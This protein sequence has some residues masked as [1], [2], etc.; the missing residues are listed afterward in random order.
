MPKPLYS[1]PIRFVQI[2]V[3]LVLCGI[4]GIAQTSPP[5]DTFDPTKARST[6]TEISALDD[7]TQSYWVYVPSRYTPTRTWPILYAFDPFGR[8]KVAVELYKNAAERYG[9]IVAGSNNSRNGRGGNSMTA[10]QAMWEDTHRRFAVNQDRAYTTGMSGGARVATAFALYCSNCNI[11]GVIA[12]AAGYPQLKGTA[13]QP[14]NTRFLYYVTVGAEDFNYPELMALRKK[15]E[16]AAEPCKVKIFAG[17]HGWAPP[18]VVEDALAWLQL[19]AMQMGTEKADSMFVGQMWEKAKS[20]VAEDQ[21]RGDA[22]S[23][24]Y[25]LRSLT[26]DF[27][28]LEDTSIFLQ[29]LADLRASRTLKDA[30]Q[31]EQKE[32]EKQHDLTGKVLNELAHVG[33]ADLDEQPNLRQ[34][35]VTEMLGLQKH[36]KSDNRDHSV[37]M[38]AYWQL[39]VAGEE[40]G[41][42]AL[43]ANQLSV[44]QTYFEL[45][46]QAAPDQPFPLVL[47]AEVSNRAGNKK[48]AL[49]AIEQAVQHGLKNA[50][51]LTQDPELQSLAPEPE[52]QRIV[53]GLHP[54]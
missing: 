23:E 20:E 4:A 10:A 49:K 9:Y 27:K 5:V 6:V 11:A 3:G 40:T 32:S 52:F 33:N 46:R 36:G 42:D 53:K 47:L 17:E 50:E 35:I 8:G 22:L 13:P 34:Q 48:A 19:K 43:S 12:Q 21:Q 38:R 1:P 51:T 37:Y 30:R 54:E 28:G 24:Y 14:A 26:E 2:V 16:D 25:A 7:P 31:N 44:A 41:Q 15:K 18:E 29:K 39:L 45:M